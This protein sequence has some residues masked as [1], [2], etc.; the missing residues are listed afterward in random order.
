LPQSILVLSLFLHLIATVIWIGGLVV[1]VIMVYPAVSRALKDNPALYAFLSGLRKRFAPLSNLSLVVLVATGLSQMTADK[2]Y[3]GFLTFDNEW[4]RV[5]LA[6]HITIIGMV[7]SGGALQWFVVP[8]LERVSLLLEHGK[9]DPAEFEKLRRREVR[10]TWLSVLL[11]IGV[12]G[13]S[14]WATA[15]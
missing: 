1:T 10:L 11:G 8:A 9:G 13:F 3:D 14:A 5:M 12:L 6:K 4:T 15:L 7:I 2:Y